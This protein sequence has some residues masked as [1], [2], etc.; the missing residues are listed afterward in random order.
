MP[1]LSQFQSLNATL[2]K[3]CEGRR[4]EIQLEIGGDPSKFER[5]RGTPGSF[6][7][8]ELGLSTCHARGEPCLKRRRSP[9]SREA[10]SP[11]RPPLTPPPRTPG[12]PGPRGT[13]RPRVAGAPGRAPRR[14]VEASPNAALEPFAP[15]KAQRCATPRPEEAAKAATPKVKATP[16]TKATAEGE[17]VVRRPRGRPPMV[18]VGKKRGQAMQWNKTLGASAPS[19]SLCPRLNDEACGSSLEVP[20]LWEAHSACR[21]LVCSFKATIIYNN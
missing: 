18:E 21:P 6:E 9:E 20:M 19:P 4:L 5:F 16:K 14:R 12:T 7:V 11:V 1:S 13:P 10:A 3:C 17:P 8:L 15:R 2:A